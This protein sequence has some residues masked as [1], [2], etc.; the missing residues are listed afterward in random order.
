MTIYKKY[1]L[2]RYLHS[3]YEVYK[4]SFTTNTLERIA[5]DRIIHSRDEA[6]ELVNED[7]K[8]RLA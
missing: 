8:S 5:S 3:R 6:K 2:K 1:I 4:I 7:I